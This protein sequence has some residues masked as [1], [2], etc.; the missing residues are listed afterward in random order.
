MNPSLAIPDWFARGNPTRSISS[1][2]LERLSLLTPLE[3]YR[4]CRSLLN[5][6]RQSIRVPESIREFEA[7]LNCPAA[8]M[9]QPSIAA[10]AVLSHLLGNPKQ[11]PIVAQLFPSNAPIGDLSAVRQEYRLLPIPIAREMIELWKEW[12][13]I[14]DDEELMKRL[15][16]A[17]RWLIDWKNFECLYYRENEFDEEECIGPNT[18]ERTTASDVFLGSLRF[19]SPSLSACLTLSGWNTGIGTIKIANVEIRAF[20]PQKFPLS[21]MKGFGIAQISAHTPTIQCNSDGFSLS[22]WTRCF[23]DPT[24]W[25]SLNANGNSQSVQM[26]IRWFGVEPNPVLENIE[27]APFA[28]AFYVRATSCTLEDGTV[29]LPQSLRRFEGK[30]KKMMFDKDVTIECFEGLSVQVIPLAGFGSFWGATFLIS[31]EFS[32]LQNQ[33]YFTIRSNE[34]SKESLGNSLS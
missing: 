25:L 32:A 5:R 21:D 4:F 29:L 3:H 20:G 24:I 15:D 22:G 23:A 10:L 6:S 12:N 1:T 26:A 9:Y 8:T 7:A 17:N 30:I 31:F 14:N 18:L 13:H 33:A 19:S 34:I 27:S 16:E 2:N 28:M 11:D